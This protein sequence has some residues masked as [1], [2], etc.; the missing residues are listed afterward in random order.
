MHIYGS[1][2][3]PEGGKWRALFGMTVHVLKNQQKYTK[4]EERAS[5]GHR[6]ARNTLK[7]KA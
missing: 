3:Q 2:Q 7:R 1:G 4:K 6:R 5:H